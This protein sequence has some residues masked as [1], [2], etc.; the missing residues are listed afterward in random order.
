MGGMGDLTRELKMVSEYLRPAGPFG[1]TDAEMMRVMAAKSMFHDV[2]KFFNRY[3]KHCCPPL[4]S[5]V[6]GAG[7]SL[8]YRCFSD[9]VALGT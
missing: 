2:D 7:H 8:S 4:A 5:I 3:E 1:T 6:E 9:R